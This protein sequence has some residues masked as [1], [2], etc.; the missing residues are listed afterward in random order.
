MF[1]IGWHFDAVRD[2]DIRGDEREKLSLGREGGAISHVLEDRVD[3]LLFLGILP[4]C[5]STRSTS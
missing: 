4:C 5:K 3:V 2:Y 1:R